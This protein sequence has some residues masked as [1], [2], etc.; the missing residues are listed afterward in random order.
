M[1]THGRAGINIGG[2]KRTA[3]EVTITVVEK[4]KDDD[5]TLISVLEAQPKPVDA[6]VMR[7]VDEK[8]VEFEKRI[9]NVVTTQLQKAL[10][11]KGCNLEVKFHS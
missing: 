3:E 9:E 1:D 5:I 7:K 6:V 10:M 8:L 4:T 11:R 2:T